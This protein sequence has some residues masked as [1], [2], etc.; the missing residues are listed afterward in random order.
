MPQTTVQILLNSR[1]QIDH[2]TIILGDFNTLLSPLDTSSKQNPTKET[3]EHN[4]T[5]NNLDLIDIYRIFHPSTSRFTFFSAAHGTF[6]KIDH[7]LCHKA[8]LGKCKKIEILSCV[9][10]GH[11]GLRVEVNDKIKNRNYSNTWR[12]NNMLLN[13][14]WITENIREEIKKFLEV[15]END[16][17]TYQ[18]LWDTM[19][20]VLRGKFMAWS[21]FQKRIKSQQ[22]NDLTLK[23][24]VL[25]KEEQNNS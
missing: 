12:L 20:A 15:N 18:N 1:N 8:A 7:M 17:T 22:L 6:S 19:K 9:L 14:T 16:D 23:L 11:N 21:A 3:I 2:N 5:I 25:E 4:N 10:S 24:K 13:E